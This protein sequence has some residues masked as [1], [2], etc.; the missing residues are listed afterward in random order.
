VR[1]VHQRR[2]KNQSMRIANFRD[3]LCHGVKLCLTH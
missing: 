1:H 3:G 2:V